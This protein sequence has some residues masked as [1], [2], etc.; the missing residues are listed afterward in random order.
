MASKASSLPFSPPPLFSLFML[1]QHIRRAFL[2]YF[3]DKGHTWVGSSPVLPHDDPTLLFTN[4]GMNQFK[5][6]FLG[7]SSRDY[8]RAATSQKCIRVGGKHNDL[9]N[10]GHTSRHLTFFEMLGN[11][12]FGDYFKEAAIQF[13]W[14][15]STEV[16]EFDK[17]RIWP[18]VFREDDEAFALWTR[19]VPKER[20]TRLGE[21]DNFWAMGDTGP[22]GPCSELLFD[23]GSA[24]GNSQNPAEDTTGERYLEFWNLVFMQYNRDGQSTLPL[25]KPSIDTGAGLERI[26]SLRMGVESVFDTD[27]LRGLIEQIEQICGIPYA[28]DDKA[29]AFRVVADHMRALSFA[30][31]D[32]AQPSNLDRGYVLRKVLRRAVRYGRQLG[33][34]KP[35]LARLL[36]TLIALMGEDYPELRQAQLRIEELLTQEEEAFLRTLCKGGNLLAQVMTHAK[37]ENGIISGEDAFRL[38]DT[39]GLPFDEI[40]L[41]AKDHQLT[42]DHTRYQLLE[43]EA[44]ER[45][46]QAHKEVSQVATVHELED[47]ATQNG[48]TSFLGYHTDKAEATLVAILIEG[49][50]VEK[51]EAGQQ[52]M[53]LLDGSPFYAE[54]GG[55]VG[56]TGSITTPKAQFQ[57][58]DCKAPFKGLIGHIGLLETGHLQVGDKVEAAIDS[59]R[60]QKIANNH[61][62]THLLHWALQEVLGPHVRQAGSVVD[63]D[64]LRFDFNHHKPL[65]PEQ[66]LQIENLVNQAIRR[67]TPVQSYEKPY[68]EV[69]HNQEIKQFFGEKYSS[70]VR[71]IDIDASKELCGGTHTSATGNI[72]YF[73]LLKESS[74]AAEVRRIEAATGEAAELFA[75]QVENTLQKAASKLQVPSH[76]LLERLDKMAEELASLQDTL[77][78]FRQQKRHQLLQMLNSHK[79]IIREVPLI[80]GEVDLDNEEMRALAE[81][82]IAPLSTGI[83]L[84]G[85]SLQ[86]RAQLYLRIHP[87]LVTQGV[88]AQALIRELAPLIE[89]NG[90][91]Q[92]TAAT[93]GGKAADKIPLALLKVRDFIP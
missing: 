93:A 65:T 64:R 1:T 54:R 33:L 5:D 47:F 74:I 69:R 22:C 83:I 88:T 36:P 50:L 15:V 87:A 60:R 62:A 28:H 8:T 38:K 92:P 81:E 21:K 40:T 53:L 70:T 71:V 90:G 66:I 68:E 61:T 75:Q 27:V 44:K 79:Q 10:V 72:G 25:P 32:G 12:S 82:L 7:R 45:S 37:Q 85:S 41:L 14:E 34:D 48:P 42:V 39:Y 80:T 52:A 55:Q 31:A 17:E 46:R 43:K 3:K 67:N 9:E 23:R 6:V 20:I 57:V 78:Q 77:K 84:L 29:A 24:Y 13:A 59:D 86:G 56:D 91:G 76:K 73:R 18:T 35:F 2:Q 63:S 49:H 30:I 11:F 51:I 19:Y 4:A 89:G 26:V 58:T 16:F